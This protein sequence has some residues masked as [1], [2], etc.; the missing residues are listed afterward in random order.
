MIKLIWNTKLLLKLENFN[1]AHTRLHRTEHGTR[2]ENQNTVAKYPIHASENHY[3]PI[4]S[5]RTRGM[6]FRRNGKT[7]YVNLA[8]AWSGLVAFTKSAPR[9]AVV[10]CVL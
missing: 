10:V 4:R 7:D 3:N 6:I 8:T 9:S 2:K 5:A 1:T